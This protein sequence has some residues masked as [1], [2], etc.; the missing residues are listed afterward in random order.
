MGYQKFQIN[1]SDAQKRALL[2]GK[3]VRLSLKALKGG[4]DEVFLTATQQ[5]RFAK[6][7]AAGKGADLRF[8]N[9]QARFNSKHGGS[10][11]GFLKGVGKAIAGVGK[12]LGKQVLNNIVPLAVSRGQ[13]LLP[14]LGQQ[15]QGLLNQGVGQ[16][17]QQVGRLDPGLG[18]AVQQ[19]GEDRVSGNL[20]RL[21]SYASNKIQQ[22]GDRIQARYGRGMGGKRG[23]RS[24]RAAV[25]PRVRP[26][27]QQTAM[28]SYDG[29]GLY[30]GGGLYPPGY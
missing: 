8:S 2:Q 11:F 19:Y 27:Q 25:M 21:G 26:S 1:V 16:I 15:A 5:K 6:A 3:S 20:D 12:N 28:M 24:V 14:M 10:F 7:V 22:T 30:A 17:A 29:A 9:A 4:P 23:G 18:A 13:A